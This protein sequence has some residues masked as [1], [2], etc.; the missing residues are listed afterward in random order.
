MEVT[1]KIKDN[2]YKEIVIPPK[3]EGGESIVKRKL[4]KK[5]VLT[6]ITLDTN[7]IITTSDL[8]NNKGNIIKN[9]CKIHV[10]EVGPIVV[11]HSREYINSI[12]THKYNQIG[13]R[14]KH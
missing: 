2:L 13:F 6:N 8:L 1:L 14:T 3:N 4:I 9:Y 5:N 7:D 11:N 10:K 12:K